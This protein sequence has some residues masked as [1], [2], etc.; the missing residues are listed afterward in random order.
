MISSIVRTFF[1]ENYAELLPEHYTCKV[2][3]RQH[4]CFMISCIVQTNY[5]ELLPEHYTWKDII[6]LV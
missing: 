5:V 3:L 1:R 4:K 2:Y 6:F